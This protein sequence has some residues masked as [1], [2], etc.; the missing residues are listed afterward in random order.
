M[1]YTWLVNYDKLSGNDRKQAYS[2]TVYLPLSSAQHIYTH[3]GLLLAV[4]TWMMHAVDRG[5]TYFQVKRQNTGKDTP[6]FEA[7]HISSPVPVLAKC[8]IIPS[9]AHPCKQSRTVDSGLGM[10]LCTMATVQ[11]TGNETVHNGYSTS[12]WSGNENM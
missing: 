5:H 8:N 2:S 9:Q 10:R 3:V 1:S 12:D 11:W 4:Y 6:F 7:V